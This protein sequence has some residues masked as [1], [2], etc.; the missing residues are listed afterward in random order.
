[1]I[2]N[3]ISMHFPHSIHLS[4]SL[5]KICW[6]LFYMLNLIDHCR[7]Q[8]TELFLLNDCRNLL[9]ISFFFILSLSSLSFLHSTFSDFSN[10]QI[11]L[12]EPEIKTFQCLGNALSIKFKSVLCDLTPFLT[13]QPPFMPLFHLL[14]VL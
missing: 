7:V 12:C 13:P 14:S 6:R 5:A 9:V 2:T 4:I 8:A 3:E 10:I 11:W 1:M